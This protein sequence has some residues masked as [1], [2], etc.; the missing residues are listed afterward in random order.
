VVFLD[1][2]FQEGKS[3]KEISWGK[4][5]TAEMGRGVKKQMLEKKKKHA[6]GQ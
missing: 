2:I 6:T 4:M 5:V 3:V 1:T